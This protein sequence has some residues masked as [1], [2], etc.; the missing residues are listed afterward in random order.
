M[1]NRLN[2]FKRKRLRALPVSY[3]QWIE[4]QQHS[5]GSIYMSMSMSI[6]VSTVRECWRDLA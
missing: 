6:C 1:K 2:R 4:F 3:C 5:D